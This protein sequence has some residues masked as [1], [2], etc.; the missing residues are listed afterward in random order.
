MSRKSK[1]TLITHELLQIRPQLYDKYTG[2]PYAVYEWDVLGGRISYRVYNDTTYT[3]GSK[4]IP[5]PAAYCDSM[6]LSAV[7]RMFTVD[8]P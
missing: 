3:D 8:K 4:H 7:K 1:A 2:I 6:S 5:Y